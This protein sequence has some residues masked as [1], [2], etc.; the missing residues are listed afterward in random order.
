MSVEFWNATWSFLTLVVFCLT[1][2]SAIAQLRHVAA[3]NQINA[4]M[5]VQAD[6]QRP[7]LQH[8]LHF[9]QSGLAERLADPAYRAE[10]AA[11]GFVD[12]LDHPEMEA[13]NWFNQ[14]GTLVKNGFVDEGIFLELF[15]R[16]VDRNWT[17]LSPAIALLRRRRGA[18]QYQNFEYLAARYRAWHARY[19]QG[20]YPSRTPRLTPVDSWLSAD[21]AAPGHS[22]P[23]AVPPRRN[24]RSHR[25]RSCSRAASAVY[26]SEEID[27]AWAGPALLCCRGCRYRTLA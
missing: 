18:T 27:E 1:A 16:L 6:F 10:L 20:R 14:V 11:L 26:W 19:P 23:A 17:L 24:A 2:V 12:P 22:R 9:V 3:G 13:C 4:L 21:D 5:S 15:G 8:A 25:R 7:S